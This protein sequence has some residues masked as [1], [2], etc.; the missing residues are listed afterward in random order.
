MSPGCLYGF[1][2]NKYV[3]M[4]KSYPWAVEIDVNVVDGW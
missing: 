2:S 1:S 3:R 4:Q